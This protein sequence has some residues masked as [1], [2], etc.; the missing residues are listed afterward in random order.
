[1]LT[2]SWAAIPVQGRGADCRRVKGRN[3]WQPAGL[4]VGRDPKWTRDKP[5][6]PLLVSTQGFE[7]HPLEKQ[8]PSA[9]VKS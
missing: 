4:G 8:E 2:S 5:R 6:G 3:A 1:M 7:N 9:A